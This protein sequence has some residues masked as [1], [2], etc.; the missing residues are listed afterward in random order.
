M[1]FFDNTYQIRN[2]KS[3]NNG[4]TPFFQ[5]KLAI[6]TPGDS[7]EQQADAVAEQVMRMK[8]SFIQPKPMAGIQRKCAHCEDEE[9]SMQRKETGGA[10]T[11]AGDGLENYIDN[12]QTGGQTMPEEVR[13]FYEPRFGY[14]FST[15]KL[16]TDSVAAKSAQ[17]DHALAYTSGNN[18][19]F[20][21]GQF[22]PGTDSGKKLL[23]HELTHVVQQGNSKNSIQR[24]LSVEDPGKNI[25]NPGGKGLVDTNG[26]VAETYLQEI[27]KAGGV[28]VNKSGDVDMSTKGFCTDIS[29]FNPW[30]GTP[31]TIPSAAKTS[32]TAVGCT[33][34]CDII[35]SSNTWKIKIDDGSWP[36]TDFDDHVKATTIGSGGSGGIVTTRS[37]N[38]PLKFGAATASGKIM[39]I[40]PW[41]ILGHEL[42]GHAWMGDKGDH[43]K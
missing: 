19:V 12:L 14:D 3:Y 26:H 31:I 30:T 4:N 16:H 15:V 24:K 40:D 7:Y 11:K 10:K 38:S 29:F 20:N 5:P 42:C 32:S 25:P 37:P 13:N 27:C 33:C 43:A 35:N 41:L 6:N 23:A 21:N 39:D 22:S 2:T 1:N 9:K 36:H 34:L 28:T 17:S 18:I 8:D